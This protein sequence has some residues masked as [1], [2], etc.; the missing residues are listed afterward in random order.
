MNSHSN[1]FGWGLGE[2]WVKLKLKVEKVVEK[3]AEKFKNIFTYG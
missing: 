3:N 1:K 2:N